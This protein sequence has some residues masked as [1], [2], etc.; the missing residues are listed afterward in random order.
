LIEDFYGLNELEYEEE[1]EYIEEKDTSILQ[2]LKS[3]I[4]LPFYTFIKI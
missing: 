3:K 1:A 2:S 4:F